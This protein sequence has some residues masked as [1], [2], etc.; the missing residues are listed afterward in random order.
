MAH[1]KAFAAPYKLCIY[2][3]SKPTRNL[4]INKVKVSGDVGSQRPR[5]INTEIIC[6]GSSRNWHD[7][8]TK[9]YERG[10][11]ERLCKGRS[12]WRYVYS[13]PMGRKYLY[14][15]VEPTNTYFILNG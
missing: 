14:F 7:C 12:T 9:Y 8:M 3:L 10:R 2:I 1:P 13:A 6:E 11:G 4:G 15:Y 5:R